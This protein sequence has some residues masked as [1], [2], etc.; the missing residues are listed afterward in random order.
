MR[1]RKRAC[2]CA[3][4]R[5]SS[6]PSCRREQRQLARTRCMR[7]QCHGAVRLSVQCTKC[8]LR[9]NRC[10]LPTS[11]TLL[12]L[13]APTHHMNLQL[14]CP[15]FDRQRALSSTIYNTIQEIQ[16]IAPPKL[17]VYTGAPLRRPDLSLNMH[18]QQSMSYTHWAARGDMASAAIPDSIS[19]T[20]TQCRTGQHTAADGVRAH[21]EAQPHRRADATP[22][23][24]RPSQAGEREDGTWEAAE[25]ARPQRQ[26]GGVPLARL[27]SAGCAGTQQRLTLSG[28]RASRG[29]S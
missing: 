18:S 15:V 1:Q 16:V 4:Y 13:P 29:Q 27:G 24:G 9:H 25:L 12:V 23:E 19:A 20:A 10:T 17:Q 22:S 8:E 28:A 11:P 3:T 6:A 14:A 2:G 7:A 5:E 26:T 21:W